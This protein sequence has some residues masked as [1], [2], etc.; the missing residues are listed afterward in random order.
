M[1]AKK[2]TLEYEEFTYPKLFFYRKASEYVA[3]TFMAL[4]IL[5]FLGAPVLWLSMFFALFFLFL[6]V[7]GISPLLTNHRMTKRRLIIRQGW[8]F[9]IVI[10]VKNIEDVVRLETG[11]LGLKGAIGQPILYVTSSD[12]NLISIILR[13]PMKLTYILGRKVENVVLNVENEERFIRELTER[14]RSFQSS[15]QSTD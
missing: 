7:F 4:F 15:P 9:K 12:H 5:A 6:L 10:P 11:K 2:I 8:Y 1:S 3:L 14:I 13:D